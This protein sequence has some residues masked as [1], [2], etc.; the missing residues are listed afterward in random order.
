MAGFIKYGYVEFMLG[1]VASNMRWVLKSCLEAYGGAIVSITFNNSKN[2]SI[3]FDR[4]NCSEYN[5]LS[6]PNNLIWL[7]EYHLLVQWAEKC[8]N[9]ITS[10]LVKG[11]TLYAPYRYL[12]IFYKNPSNVWLKPTRSGAEACL[13]CVTLISTSSLRAPKEN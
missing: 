2:E 7:N 9:E 5:V 10:E 11:Y 1:Y 13:T 6:G 4:V 3:A 12:R 8:A